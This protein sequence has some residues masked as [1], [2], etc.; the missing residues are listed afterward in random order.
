VVWRVVSGLHG[1]SQVRQSRCSGVFNDRNYISEQEA[2][3]QLGMLDEQEVSCHSSVWFQ[4]FQ[5]PL[6][7]RTPVNSHLGLEF[8]HTF[9]FCV[10]LAVA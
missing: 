6:S 5:L 2:G 4:T 1:V 8:G 7:P 10:V 9:R 3:Y